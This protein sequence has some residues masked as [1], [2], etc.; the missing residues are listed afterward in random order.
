MKN[1]QLPD[2]VYQRAE[3][4]AAADHVSVDVWVAAVVNE[5]AVD[6]SRLQARAAKGSLDRLREVLAKVSDAAPESADQL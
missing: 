4:L 1:V 6:W 5:K 2:E 3:E